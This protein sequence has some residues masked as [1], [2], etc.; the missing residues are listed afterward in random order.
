MGALNSNRCILAVIKKDK[1][2]V[3]ATNL[4]RVPT[5]Q[6]VPT[7]N[8]WHSKGKQLEQV[9]NTLEQAPEGS[10]FAFTDGSRLGG[11]TAWATTYCSWSKGRSWLRP[12]CSMRS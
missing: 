6:S 5:S 8:K 10:V 3:G 2:P 12:K 4:Q 1:S 9:K 7:K 11:G